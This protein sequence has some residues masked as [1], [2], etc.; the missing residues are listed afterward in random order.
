MPETNPRALEFVLGERPDETQAGLL[1][2][3]VQKAEEVGFFERLLGGLDLRM[4]TYVYTHRNKVETLVA[5]VAVGC[6]HIAEIQ[7]KLVPDTAAA[8]LFDLPRFPDQSQVNA[9]LRACG[10]EQVAHLE[11]AHATLL[12]QHSRAGDRRQWL[13]LPNGQRVLPVDLD[14]TYLVTRSTKAEGATRGYFGRKRGQL[15]YKKSVALLGGHVQEVLYQGLEA[16]NVHGQAAVPAIV[17]KLARLLVARGIHPEEVLVRGDSAYGSVDLLR[18]LQA[19]HYHYVLSG[20][21][22]ATAQHLAERLPATAVWH[23][24]GTDSNG[25]QVW[26]TD[27]GEQDLAAHDD[28]VADPPVRTRVVVVVRVS[29]RLRKQ[30]GRGAPGAVAETHVSFEHYLTDYPAAV[31]SAAAVLD[32]YGGRETEESFFRAEQDAFGAHYLRT[33]HGD[34]EA[35]FLWILASTVNLLRWVQHTTLSGTVLEQVGLSRLVTQAMRIPA[36]IERTTDKCRVIFPS[37]ARLVRQ[38]VNLWD[39][40]F[41]Q[42]A[43]PL[44]FVNDSS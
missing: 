11:E 14:Q 41:H 28:R 39:V 25:A 3:V 29:Q 23:L 34:R 4:K 31:L 17:T 2:T 40:Q 33:K 5:S 32:W 13:A 18:Q 30:H 1:V 26:S 15:G 44:V 12:D 10:P 8:A 6:R 36:T 9:F 43:L 37:T 38:L 21:T 22:P 16:G 42:L 24:R 19:A 27:A 7:T 20:Y 35:A